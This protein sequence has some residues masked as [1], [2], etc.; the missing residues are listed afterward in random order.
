MRAPRKNSVGLAA[1]AASGLLSI[2]SGGFGRADESPRES[3]ASEPES[4]ASTSPARP[5]SSTPILLARRSPLPAEM[6]G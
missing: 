2:L 4:L 3:V 6:G 5:A 1:L